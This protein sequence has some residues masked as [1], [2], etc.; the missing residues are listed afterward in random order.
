MGDHTVR[1]DYE[2]GP[3]G[4]FGPA[5]R[6]VEVKKGD[7]ILFTVG[8]G[9]VAD[10]T[11]RITLLG[12]EHKGRDIKIEVTAAFPDKTFYD[13]A[14]LDKSGKTRPGASVIGSAGGEIVLVGP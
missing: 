13:C 5:P 14:L 2:A 12:A 7:R 4:K 3:S 9:A 10:D 1:L 6:K 11:L 8:A